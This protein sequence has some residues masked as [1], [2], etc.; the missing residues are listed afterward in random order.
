MSNL[1]WA[2]ALTLPLFIQFLLLPYAQ[3][4]ANSHMNPGPVYGALILAACVVLAVRTFRRRSYLPALP[5]LL[6]LGLQ[7]VEFFTLY[8]QGCAQSG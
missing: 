7:S 6:C 1:K 3:S 8:C 2:I 5:L 4:A